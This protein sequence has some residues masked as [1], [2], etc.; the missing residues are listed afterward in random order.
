ML[1]AD[2]DA[3]LIDWQH[4]QW[5]KDNQPWVPDLGRP[6]WLPT[7]SATKTSCASRRPVSTPYV[8][9]TEGGES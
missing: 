8:R 6:A 1:Q 7:A 3:A 4:V 9:P 2:P 5:L